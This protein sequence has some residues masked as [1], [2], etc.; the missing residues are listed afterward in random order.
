MKPKF[1]LHIHRT[2]KT[3]YWTCSVRFST[4]SVDEMKYSGPCILTSV[5]A[6]AEAALLMR[7]ATGHAYR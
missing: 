3:N 2:D 4:P 6:I 1:T 5:A 7:R